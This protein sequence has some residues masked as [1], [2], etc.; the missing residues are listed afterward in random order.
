MTVPATS[1]RGTELLAPAGDSDCAFAAFQYGADAVYLGMK[2][3]SA[4]AEAGN[5]TAEEVGEIAAYAHS[6]VP[7]RRVYLALNTLVKNAE[8]TRAAETLYDAVSVGVDAVIV[9]DLGIARIAREHFPSLRLHASTQMAIHNIEGVMAAAGMGFSRVTLARELTLDEIDGIS[10]GSG[11]EIEIF[12]HGALCYSYSGLCLYS[13]IMR[14]SSGNRGRCRYPCRG[15]FMRNTRDGACYPF[16]MKDLAL[17]EVALEAVKRGVRAVKIEGRMKNALYVSTVVNFYRMLLDGTLTEEKRRELEEDMQTVFARPWTRL[18]SGG[19]DAASPIDSET[20]GHRGAPVGTVAGVRRIG[21]D[22]HWLMFTT[23]R[24]IELHD[25]LQVDLPDRG[26]PYGFA[27]EAIRVSSGRSMVFEVRAGSDIEVRLP[28]DHPHIPE[29]APVYCASSQAVKNRYRFERP[30]KGAFMKKAELSVCIDIAPAVVN[31]EASVSGVA[32]VVSGSASG[33]FGPAKDTGKTGTAA[34]DAFGKLGGTGLELAQFICRNPQGLF[35][36]VSRL[37]EL[38]RIVVGR[39]REVMVSERDRQLSAIRRSLERGA[40]CEKPDRDGAD[41][42]SLRIDQALQVNLFSDEDWGGVDELV[43]PVGADLSGAGKIPSAV[44]LRYALPLVCRA[45]EMKGLLVAVR[46]AVIDRV[47][48]WMIPGMWGIEVLKRAGATM[49]ECDVTG[50]WSLYALNADACKWYGEN[51]VGGFAF[52]P[53]D[54]SDNMRETESACSGKGACFVYMDVPLFVSETVPVAGRART[55]APGE[56]LEGGADGG[57][58]LIVSR[59]GGK[60]IVTSITPLSLASRI[61]HLRGMGIRR[62][63]VDCSWRDYGAAETRAI[64]RDARAWKT[65]RGS[66]A[67]FDRGLR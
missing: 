30:K 9:Q 33:E 16:S 48:R 60:V 22:G 8:I 37:N 66:I 34:R 13:S 5:F 23:T 43:V 63:V 18:Y 29:G 57:E 6:L 58:R 15:E 2:S 42:W 65:I 17:G 38:R 4:R 67:N 20:V 61:Q 46:E 36:P 47:K 59:R 32:Q 39:A 54:D 21:G 25:G 27:V 52:S 49:E 55:S 11:I 31:V 40:R 12:V 53:E 19:R 44:K 7:R 3:F 35:V 62:F 24:R 64:W 26:R 28:E 45:W 51:G 56:V 10:R 50:D 14:G 41:V 1:V